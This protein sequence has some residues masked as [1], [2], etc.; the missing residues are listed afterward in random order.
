LP[1]ILSAEFADGGAAA[2][3]PFSSP[4]DRAAVFVGTVFPC[5]QVLSFRQANSVRCAWTDAST[6][7]MF[8]TTASGLALGSE[9]TLLG[10][11]LK[12][13]CPSPGDTECASYQYAAAQT[14]HITNG[15]DSTPRVAVHAPTVVSNAS[16]FTLDVLSSQGNGGRAG[17]G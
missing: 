2:I 12:N 1:R 15:V 8:A 17:V 10:N 3:I 13:K 16:S 6:I 7:R 5:G 4:T 9:V 11:I 14:V